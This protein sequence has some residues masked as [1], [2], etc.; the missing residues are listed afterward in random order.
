MNSDLLGA[1]HSPTDAESS[2]KLPFS[3][4]KVLVMK[5][6]G[7]RAPPHWIYRVTWRWTTQR[8]RAVFEYMWRVHDHAVVPTYIIPSVGPWTEEDTNCTGGAGSQWTI[9]ERLLRAK[10]PGET[11]P[12]FLQGVLVDPPPFYNRNTRPSPWMPSPRYH[13]RGLFFSLPRDGE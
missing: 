2:T 13:G 8:H 11:I 3:H 12:D 1:H 9:D 5:A 6:A 4:L 10:Y 7:Y